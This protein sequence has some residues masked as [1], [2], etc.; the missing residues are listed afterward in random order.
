M[1]K[2]LVTG[3]AQ[4]IGA[5]IVKTLHK[6]NYD[7]IIHYNNSANEASKLAALLNNDRQNSVTIVQAELNTRD[8]IDK[9]R[10]SVTRLDLLV[11]NAS[12]FC[13]TPIGKIDRSTW[14]SIMDTNL[15][16]PFFLSQSL[17]T[18]L[19]KSNG[20]IVNIVDIHSDR[21]LKDHS[22]YSISKSGIAM[23]TKSLAKD[24]APGVR[25]CGISPGYILSPKGSKKIGNEENQ[26]NNKIALKRH[27]TVEDIANTVV[28]L[29]NSTYITGQ[30]INVDG[31]RTLNQ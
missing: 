5:Q 13:S 19:H 12:I 6:N 17:A 4:R 28:F 21:P 1:K 18:L 20:C 22:V 29:A 2:A 7:I 27:G 16:S 23:M 15:M 24:L 10:N 8:G 26:A 3:G 11:N 9:L 14:S 25:V 31:G 30:I